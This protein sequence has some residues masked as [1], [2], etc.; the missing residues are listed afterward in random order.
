MCFPALA[1]EVNTGFTVVFI[2]NLAH[3]MDPISKYRREA[4]TADQENFP[5]LYDMKVKLV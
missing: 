3:L 1:L 5:F 2:M 4:M